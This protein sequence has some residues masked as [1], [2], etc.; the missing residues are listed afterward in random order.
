MPYNICI[1]LL[2]QRRGEGPK[3]SEIRKASGL[4]SLLDSQGGRPG[5]G[6]EEAAVVKRPL[7]YVRSSLPFPFNVSHEDGWVSRILR[8]LLRF[9]RLTPN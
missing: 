1:A 8:T 7:L 5:S 3:I 9:H 2:P 4:M 6:V